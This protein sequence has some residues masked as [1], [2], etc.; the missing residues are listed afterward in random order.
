MISNRIVYIDALKGFGIL[1][2]VVGHVIQFF[3]DEIHVPAALKLWT[4]IYSFHMPL[5][6]F[7][8]GMVV[9]FE[10]PDSIKLYQHIRRR[11]VRL[12]LPFIGWMPFICLYHRYSPF[13]L[14]VLPDQG[15]WFLEVLFLTDTFFWLA[16]YISEYVHLSIVT[17]VM[18]IVLLVVVNFVTSGFGLWLTA[19]YLPFYF[20]GFLFS[21]YVLHHHMVCKVVMS[22]ALLLYVFLYRNWKWGHFHDITDITWNYVVALC[23]ILFIVLTVKNISEKFTLG[24]LANLGKESLGIYAVHLFPIWTL[25]ELF[26][27]YSISHTTVASLV[28][29]FLTILFAC[30]GVWVLSHIPILRNVLLGK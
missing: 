24:M 22:I 21:R 9:K 17:I 18:Y 6:F 27:A 13:S 25:T 30:W 11:F 28:V 7:L 29:L 1:L 26:N 23:A 20:L 2:V 3:T 5:F 10:I 12:I 15:L 8:S 19:Y 4:F 14:F 16:L